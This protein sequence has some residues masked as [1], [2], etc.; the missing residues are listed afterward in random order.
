MDDANAAP[1]PAQAKAGPSW[2][3]T[4]ESAK[5]AAAKSAAVRSELARQRKATPRPRRVRIPGPDDASASPW[6]RERIT[7]T[8]GQL[9]ALDVALARALEAGNDSRAIE[10]IVSSISRLAE[11]ERKLD[12]RPDPG[13]RRPGR[14]K[15]RPASP[16]AG[17]AAPTPADVEPQAPA[18]L[19]PA[20]EPI[21]PSHS[22][23]L[24]QPDA[25][26][27]NAA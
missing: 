17:L 15:A 2:L 18:G 5:A 3:F 10:R 4:T 27:Q 19:L 25:N 24:S 9:R 7:R 1:G 20:P 13:M 22:E 14:D 21:S 26:S 11:V 6:V 16:L 12:N 23:P 8:R